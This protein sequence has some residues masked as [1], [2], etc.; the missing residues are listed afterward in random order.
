[1]NGR[2]IPVEEG[3]FDMAPT[4]PAGEVYLNGTRC[5]KCGRYYFPKRNRCMLCSSEELKDVKLGRR[6]KLFSYTNCNFPPP[7]GTIRGAFL[8]VLL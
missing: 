8:M 6:G 3:L 2:R 1:M 4:F 7:G 5:N